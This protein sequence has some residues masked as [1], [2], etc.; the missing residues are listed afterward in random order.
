MEM[1]PVSRREQIIED[2]RLRL[3]NL[4]EDKVPYKNDP[5][6][7]LLTKSLVLE[8]KV[9]EARSAD[10]SNYFRTGYAG[11]RVILWR[12]TDGV[13]S[14]ALCNYESRVVKKEALG[15]TAEEML[16]QLMPGKTI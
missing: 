15:S 5:E 10:V 4:R 16:R 7:I 9:L 3:K 8:R 11:R 14:G 2:L 13:W 12:Y 1:Q 6:Y